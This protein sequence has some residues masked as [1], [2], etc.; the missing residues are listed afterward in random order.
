MAVVVAAGR[1]F[2]RRWLLV[3]TTADGSVGQGGDWRSGQVVANAVHGVEVPWRN[4]CPLVPF[5]KNELNFKDPN[6]DLVIVFLSS[7]LVNVA[8]KH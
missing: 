7:K 3:S 2:Q 1:C 4:L 6:G 5:L 8:I